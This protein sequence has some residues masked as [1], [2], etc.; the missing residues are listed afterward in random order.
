[1]DL[2]SSSVESSMNDSLGGAGGDGDFDTG[3]QQLQQRLEKGKEALAK[4]L[5]RE[6][7]GPAQRLTE[8]LHR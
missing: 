7:W 2:S 8:H 5:S 4:I 1:M 3:T 6:V